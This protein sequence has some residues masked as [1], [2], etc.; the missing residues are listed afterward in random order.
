[1][2]SGIGLGLANPQILRYFIDTATTG[3]ATPKS[4][5]RC[6]TIP[7]RWYPRAN[8]HANQLL[9]GAGCGMAG[10]KSDAG[11]FGVSLSKAGYVVPSRVHPRRD[12]RTR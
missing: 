9:F 10:N 5:Y 4:A 1:M 8:Y 11:G 3:G 2:F 7:R 6:W 12:G